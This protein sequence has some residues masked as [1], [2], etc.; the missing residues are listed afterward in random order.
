MHPIL[1]TPA[2]APRVLGVLALLGAC[3]LCIP[4]F[5]Q[6]EAP[7]PPAPAPDNVLEAV[8]AKPDGTTPPGP[9][10]PPAASTDPAAPPPVPAAG[11]EPIL[12]E[13]PAQ[14]NSAPAATATAGAK[15]SYSSCT[16]EGNQVAITFD[17]GPH[18]TNTPRL[19]DIL[20]QKGV[21]ATFFVVGQNAAEYPEILKRIVAEGHELANHS[22]SHPVLASLSEGALREQLDKTHQAV[23]KATGV[24]MKLMRPPYGALNNPQRAWVHAHFGYRVILWDVDPL[25][26]K[27]RDAAKVEQAIVSRAHAGSI[28]L[29][30]DIHKTTVDAVPETLDQ[31]LQK[32]LKFVT[33]SELIA[34]DK[35]AAAKPPAPAGSPTPKAPPQ[36]SSAKTEAKPKSFRSSI[37]SLLRGSS[38]PASLPE[39]PSSTEKAGAEKRPEKT[40]GGEKNAEKTGEKPVSKSVPAASAGNKKFS[41]LS[42]EEVKKKWL[43]SLKR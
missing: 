33:V 18:A 1:R 11:V 19:L 22:F 17:D 40:A 36:D 25:D 23:L 21:R 2:A 39:K 28:I 34:L 30:H 14:T 8:P 31:L 6:S 7:A 29:A 26:W 12:A 41:Q 4:G 38:K 5:S 37:S 43:E 3:L 32:G 42:E 20:K 13:A 9:A 24:T 15:I 16:V 35:P 27:V 10:A